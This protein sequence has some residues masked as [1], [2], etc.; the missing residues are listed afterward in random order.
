M[1]LYALVPKCVGFGEQ[2]GRFGSRIGN[3]AAEARQDEQRAGAGPRA[4]ARG[5]GGS[6]WGSRPFGLLSLT[7]EAAE[8]L[9]LDDHLDLTLVPPTC[10]AVAANLARK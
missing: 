1:S 9:T 7:A 8:G 2:L 4:A 6:P 3:Q 5:K 10:V